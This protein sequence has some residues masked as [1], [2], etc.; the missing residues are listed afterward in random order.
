[1]PSSQS[2]GSSPSLATNGDL[3]G[4]DPVAS[5]NASSKSANNLD[6]FG[7]LME[8]SSSTGPNPFGLGQAY[9]PGASAKKTPE[10]FLGENSNLVNLDA[11]ISSNPTS[12]IQGK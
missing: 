9:P 3:S 10:N 4:F 6:S 8:F 11:L 2:F 5:R 7:G 1:M 12:Q